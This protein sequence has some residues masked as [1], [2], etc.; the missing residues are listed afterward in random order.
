MQEWA[1]GEKKSNPV[2]TKGVGWGGGLEGRSEGEDIYTH[3]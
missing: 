1:L 3:S 2:M